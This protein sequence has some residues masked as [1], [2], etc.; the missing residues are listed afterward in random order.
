MDE[1]DRRTLYP[2]CLKCYHDLH[3]MKKKIGCVNQTSDEDFGY[4]ST[5][6]IHKWPIKGTCHQEIIDFQMLPS[7]YQRHQMSPSMVEKI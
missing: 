7:G 6:C 4:F 2:M 3:P 1:Y 5:N